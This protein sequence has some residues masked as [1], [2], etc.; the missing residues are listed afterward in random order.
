MSQPV[1]K[2]RLPP[3]MTAAWMAELRK[4][5]QVW[6]EQVCSDNKLTPSAFKIGYVMAD[7]VTL[8]DSA[9]HYRKH[10]KLIIWPSQAA[11]RDRTEISVDTIRTSVATLIKR[12]HLEL[13]QRG[14]Q[15]R[16]SNEYRML[17]KAKST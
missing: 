15:V 14:N 7:Y 1:V 2:R 13:R 16:G 4:Q 10:G 5:K 6:R 11:L 3:W 17:I 9:A 8:E 12:G